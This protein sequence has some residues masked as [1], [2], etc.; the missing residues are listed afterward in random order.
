MGWIALGLGI[1]VF[2]VGIS[3]TFTMLR[4]NRDTLH[5]ANQ[6]QFSIIPLFDVV[7][8]GCT[9][10]LAIYWRN[11]PEYHRRLIFIATCALTAAGFGRF[12]EL[13]RGSFYAGVDFLILLGII[14]DWIVTRRIQ[15]VYRYAF[16]GFAAG[17]IV[18]I[19]IVLRQLNY[20]LVIVHRL[21]G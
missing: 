15:M 17:Q 19:V 9:F 20:W 5:L 21:V 7:C 14:R 1:A 13:P 6:E 4:F 10:A 11:R 16:L 3:T 8:F 12:P 18:V 2:A